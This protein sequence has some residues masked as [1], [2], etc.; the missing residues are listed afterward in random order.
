MKKQ[1]L[2]K[3]S[4]MLLVILFIAAGCGSNKSGQS[5]SSQTDIGGSEAPLSVGLYI[6]GNLGDQGFFDSANAGVQRMDKEFGAKIK[7]VEGG[8]NQ[9][10]WA[11]GLESMVSSGK[12][13]IVIAGTSQMSDITINLAKRY[14]NQKFIFFDVAIEGLPNVYSVIYDQKEGSFLA[15]AFAALVTKST[16]L[17][18]SNPDKTIGFIGGM[19]IP[20]INEFRSGYE[21]GA[22]YIDRDIK[23]ISSFVGSFSDAPKGKELGLAQFKQQ[24]VDVIFAAAGAGGL[25]MFEAAKELGTYAIGCNVNQNEVQPGTVLTSMLKNVSDSLFRAVDRYKKGELQFGVSEQLGF[26]EGG[27]GLAKDDLYSKNVPQTI[28][29][30]V[31][32]IQKKLESGEITLK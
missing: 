32:E 2:V 1:H 10:D 8:S 12:Y 29:D 31:E 18:G 27:V 23:V 4:M 17:K 24:K 25:G 15:G 19:D 3:L 21:Q 11:V 20:I 28:R 30:Q 9:T 22:Q 13:D 26:A 7:V 14:P 16:E 6:N 5:G